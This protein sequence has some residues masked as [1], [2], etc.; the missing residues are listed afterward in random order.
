MVAAARLAALLILPV[1]AA[2]ATAPRGPD[3]GLLAL[4]A[5]LPQSLNDFAL[6][7]SAMT[8]STPANWKATYR[9]EQSGSIA[10]VLLGPPVQPPVA[11][12][13]D[14]DQVRALTNLSAVALQ[15]VVGGGGVTRSPDFGVGAPDKPP[16]IRCSDL[17]LRTPSGEIARNITCGTG[18][19]G[20][21]VSISVNARHSAEIADRARLFMGHFALSLARV[22]RGEQAGES[23]PP[24]SPG[25]GIRPGE[26]IFR[27]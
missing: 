12:G 26:R 1:L 16:E 8:D 24:S 3:P 11:E 13:P 14:S 2:C 17:S 5:R 7:D 21:L 23:A 6:Q 19:G 27:L 22:L 10:V 15:A 20:G 9:H 18:I 25:Q 4:V